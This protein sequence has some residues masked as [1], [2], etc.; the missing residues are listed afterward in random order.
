M[1]SFATYPIERAP[2][3]IV[4]AKR[5]NNGEIEEIELSTR[6][7]IESDS[8][9]STIIGINGVGKSR[10]LGDLARTFS[11]LYRAQRSAAGELS[12][13]RMPLVYIEYVAFGDCYLVMHGAGGFASFFKYREN[14]KIHE[15]ICSNVVFE[16]FIAKT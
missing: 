7:N 6:K 1:S 16:A 8:V 4:R 10:F 12:N 5:V 14:C 13:K 11:Y 15:T 3:H 2:F 9:Y